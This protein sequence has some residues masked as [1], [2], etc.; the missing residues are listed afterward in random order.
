VTI[1]H[2]R[3]ETGYVLW[4]MFDSDRQLMGTL[5]HVCRDIS[6]QE[7]SVSYL[8][9]IVD[10]WVS[11]DGQLRVLDE[12]ELLSAQQKGMLDGQD[13]KHIAHWR[14]TV[15]ADHEKIIAQA[16]GEERRAGISPKA[17]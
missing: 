14:D 12:D 16:I 13:A 2:Y 15:L 5:F 9:L 10:V 11:P 6:I 8:D 3:T 7:N 17:L 1:A 4:R